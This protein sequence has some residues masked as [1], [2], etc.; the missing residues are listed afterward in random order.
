VLLGRQEP[1]LSNLPALHPDQSAGGEA[2]ALADHV[3]L[4]LDPWQQAVLHSALGESGD[5]WLTPDVALVV[6]RQNGKN[7]ILEA[8]EL[9][10]LFLFP[11][12]KLIHTA[13]LLG[14]A[15]TTFNRLVAYIASAP[16][17]QRHV[18]Q[19]RYGNGGA[20]IFLKKSAPEPAA[21]SELLFLARSGGSGRSMSVD[22]LAL[23]EAYNLPTAN[24]NAITPTMAA[25]PNPQTWFTSSAVNQL[26]H[27]HGLSL[28]RI[29]RRAI[30]G[31]DPHICYAEW[32]GDEVAFDKMRAH[33]KRDYVSDPAT[34]AIANPGL[35]I[36]VQHDFLA[37]QL[38]KLGVRGFATEHLSI[39]DWPPE[40]DEERLRVVDPALW[41]QLVDQMSLVVTPRKVFAIAVHPN[42]ATCSIAICGGNQAG[43]PHV[44]IVDERRGLAWVVDRVKELQ[45]TW[46]PATTVIDPGSPAGQLVDPLKL[47]GVRLTEV[48]SRTYAQACGRFVT[49]ATERSTERPLGGLRHRDDPRIN[50]PLDAATTR[51]L[52]GAWAWAHDTGPGLVAVT[53]ALHGFEVGPTTVAPWGFYA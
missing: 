22:F 49:A 30:D 5:K 8:R 17:L 23:D 6:S 38:R 26:E 27:P 13:H 20:G 29:R 45:K 7:A 35:G 51:P 52:M 36:R 33:E 43:V 1:R 39:G 21:G 32:S 12:K 37:S 47:A 14:A 3:G 42:D 31:R 40:P 25:R 50:G 44:E 41:E 28:A 15:M 34:W 19:I 9:A 2:I 4:H 10:G 11:E 18:Q 24:L 48:T 16:D 46:K 53:L